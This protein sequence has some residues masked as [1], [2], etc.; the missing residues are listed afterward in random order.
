MKLTE[1]LCYFDFL[2]LQSL[3]H[4]KPCHLPLHKGGFGLVPLKR[5]HVIIAWLS[6]QSKAH[7]CAVGSIRAMP[8]T[9]IPPVTGGFLLFLKGKCFP[10]DIN[11]LFIGRE[12]YIVRFY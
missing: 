4:G 5:V 10:G 7:L 3:R 1:G 12:L 9:E 8:E 11:Q 2:L 6:G